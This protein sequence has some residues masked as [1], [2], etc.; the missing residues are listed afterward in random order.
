MSG[1]SGFGGMGGMGGMG[2]A[3]GFAIDPFLAEALLASSMMPMYPSRPSPQPMFN[4]YPQMLPPTR[5]PFSG[6]Q[7][8]LN[9]QT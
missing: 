9:I 8:S 1:M 6:I 5:S 3:G 4:M 2:G 7:I